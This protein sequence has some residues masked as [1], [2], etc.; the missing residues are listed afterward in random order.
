MQPCE[1]LLV[2][3]RNGDYP[4]VAANWYETVLTNK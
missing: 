2:P 1:S 4:V 3:W